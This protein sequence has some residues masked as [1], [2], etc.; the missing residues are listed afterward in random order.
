MRVCRSRLFWALC[1][2]LSQPRKEENTTIVTRGVTDFSHATTSGGF[3]STI[4]IQINSM[5]TAS[6]AIQEVVAHELGHTLNLADCNYPSC[7][8]NSSVMESGVNAPGT[9]TNSVIGQPGPTVCDISAV[10]LTNNYFCPPPPPPP[11]CDPSC[12]NPCIA[13]QLGSAPGFIVRASSLNPRLQLVQSTRCCN[14][15]PILIDIGGQ[16]FSL[17]S[18]ATGVTFDMAGTG[19]PIQIASTAPGANNPFLP[20]PG[21][22]GVVHNGKEMSRNFTPQPSIAI[23]NRFPAPAVYDDP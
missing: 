17:T 1:A 14:E 20:L 6:A 13:K 15:S 11:T 21:D 22:D 8:V 12:C 3:L 5:I 10:G 19:N 9:T 7:P 2:M 23:P 16:G 18:A 4:P